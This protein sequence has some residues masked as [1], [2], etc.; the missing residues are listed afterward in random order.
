VIDLLAILPYYMELTL[1]NAEFGGLI[2][3]RVLRLTRVFRLFKLSR[4]MSRLIILKQVMQESKQILSSFLFI[5]AI[6]IIIFSS[7]MFIIE[8]GTYDEDSGQWLDA[9]GN[10]SQF[11][12]IPQAFYWCVTTITTVGY[13]DIVP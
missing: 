7:L 11:Y 6:G 12:S 13:G 4:Y 5:V 9:S 3:L 1:G 8:R 10:P 2:I